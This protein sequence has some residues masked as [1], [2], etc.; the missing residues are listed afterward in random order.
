MEDVFDTKFESDFDRALS[1]SRCVEFERVGSLASKR[2]S[3]SLC[4]SSLFGST[5][6]EDDVSMS[7]T[8]IGGG[9]IG[10]FSEMS[11][12]SCFSTLTCFGGGIRAGV[13]STSTVAAALAAGCG[14]S[15]TIISGSGNFGAIFFLFMSGV[16]FTS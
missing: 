6:V 14:I 7:G 4:R 5:E 16:F 12:F 9:S 2:K 11:I 13:S 10:F 1:I 3:K 8:M 15:G